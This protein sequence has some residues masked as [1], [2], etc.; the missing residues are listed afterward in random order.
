[1]DIFGS[2]ERFLS[3]DLYPYRVPV[4][5][6]AVLLV[7]GVAWL[8][9][10]AGWLARLA[11]AAR[12]RPVASG[13]VALILVFTVLP[14][15]YYLAS[16]LWTRTSLVEESPLAAAA[17]AT[18]TNAP[19]TATSTAEPAATDSATTGAGQ[20]PRTVLSGEWA[21]ADDFH[22]ARGDALI[23]ETE[24]GTFVLRLENFSVRN[25]PDLFVY[26][27][28]DPGGYT[29]AAIEL[30]T[31]KATDGAF[32]YEI[33]AGISVEEMR[34]AVVWCKQFAVLFG[35]APLQ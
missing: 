7:A 22:F 28:P 21:G 14:A 11:T 13:V 5:V 12:A 23:I 27:S 1:V 4:T 9:V 30:G 26:L 2:L 29:E 24:P 10:R 15:G 31:L 35:S 33:P 16:P 8:A 17:V 20:L 32:N 3:E 18:S 25:G 6:A 19:A 34:S